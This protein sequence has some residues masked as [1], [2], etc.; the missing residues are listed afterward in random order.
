MVDFFSGISLKL[1]D[2]NEMSLLM[3]AALRGNDLGAW[4]VSSFGFP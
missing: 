2:L 3:W 4:G 1:L